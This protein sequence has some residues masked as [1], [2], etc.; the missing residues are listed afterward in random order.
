MTCPKAAQQTSCLSQSL[1]CHLHSR[2]YF[3][4]VTLSLRYFA[5]IK[6]ETSLQAWASCS[7]VLQFKAATSDIP[8]SSACS[9]VVGGGPDGAKRATPFLGLLAVAPGRWRLHTSALA[10][11]GTLFLCSDT[12]DWKLCLDIAHLDLLPLLQAAQ[13][14][15]ESSQNATLHIWHQRISRHTRTPLRSNRTLYAGLIACG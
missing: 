3:H 1:P 5:H 6:D 12:A 15:Q 13:C 7:A 8:A 9:A 11:A 4:C 10:S 2:T 14:K